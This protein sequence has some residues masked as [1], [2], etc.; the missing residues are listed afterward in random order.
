MKKTNLIIIIIIAVIIGL[1]AGW[2]IKNASQP[3]KEQPAQESQG[4]S[5]S[6]L[7][8]HQ[9]DGFYNIQAEYPQ[10]VSADDS[11]NKKISDLVTSE[12]ETFKK[13]AKDNYEARRETAPAGSPLPETPD[14]PFDFIAE[15]QPSQ[16]NGDYISFVLNIYY[17]VGGAHGANEIHA[18]NY[19][20]KKRKEITML[21]F[22]N[23][24][25]DSLDKLAQLAEQDVT[26][27]LQS[28][29]LQMD[30]FLKQMIQQGTAATED[31]YKNFT[32]NYN[33]LTIYFEQYQVAPGAVGSLSSVFYKS[34]LNAAS[35]SSDYFR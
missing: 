4:S 8:V 13:D 21:D 3:E 15:W 26:S 31:N 5:M 28:Q 2:E 6:V 18:F 30:D 12:I 33:S 10:F 14:Q 23:S 19:D 20:V 29:G 1:I 11:F 16:I 24:S 32:F 25:Q 9:N 22:F 34:V 35:I 27:Q 7:S 17:F